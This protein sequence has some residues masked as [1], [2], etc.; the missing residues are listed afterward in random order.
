MGSSCWGCGHYFHARC[1]GL[2]D[3]TAM[4]WVC[5]A[6][7]EHAGQI[8]L[9]D[10]VLDRHLMEVVCKG[11]MGEDWEPLEKERVMAAS[12]W[13][14]WDAGR[15]WQLGAVQDRVVPPIW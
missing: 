4:V 9:R 12:K 8:G 1:L 6:C 10:L 5:P 14:R 3:N 13:L 15:L 2:G 7:R 11:E